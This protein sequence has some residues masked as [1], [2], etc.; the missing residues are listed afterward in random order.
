MSITDA[1]EQGG[2][3]AESA[4]FDSSVFLGARS[5]GAE[6]LAVANEELAGRNTVRSPRVCVCGQKEIYHADEDDLG[7][8]GSLWSYQCFSSRRQFELVI[9]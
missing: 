8:D 7:W 9:F 5:P 2:A 6:A 3:A 1:S 4:A